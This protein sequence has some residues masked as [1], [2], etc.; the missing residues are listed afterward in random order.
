VKAPPGPE[1]TPGVDLEDQGRFVRQRIKRA[2]FLALVAAVVLLVLGHKAAARGVALG[3]LFSGLNFALLSRIL[4]ARLAR[5]G[6]QGSAVGIIWALGRLAILAAPLVLAAKSDYFS[7]LATA[8]GL[9]AV[10]AAL[11]L[12]PF[13]AR[14]ARR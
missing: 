1:I 2:L 3:A 5:P 14:F 6:W 4:T 10:Q 7:L 13:W 12:E 11:L 8:A 9:F